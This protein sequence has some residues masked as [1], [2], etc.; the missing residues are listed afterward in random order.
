MSS[1]II[2]V[3][4]LS[5]AFRI[6]VKEEVPDTLIGAAK[7]IV[8]AP[9]RNLRDLRKLDSTDAANGGIDQSNTIW[10]LRDVSFDVDE[11]EVVGII[12]RNGAGKSTLLKM[13]PRLYRPSSGKLLI[14]QLDIAKVDLYSLRAQ[15]GFVPQDCLLFEGMDLDFLC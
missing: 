15:I 1:P 7:N 6:G 14:D 11:G 2:S 12:G 13:I 10:A 4:Q 5:K 9:F 3:E 8:T